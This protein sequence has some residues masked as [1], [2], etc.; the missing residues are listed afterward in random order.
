VRAALLERVLQEAWQNATC[1]VLPAE[2][3][4][5]AELSTSR[6]TLRQAIATLAEWGMVE[7]VRGSGVRIRSREHW[8]IRAVAAIVSLPGA[9]SV[10]R[11]LAADALAL[12][13]G[14]ARQLPGLIPGPPLAGRFANAFSVAERAW[15]QR[16]APARFVAL[17]AAVART[18]LGESDAWPSAWLWNDL[19]PVPVALASRLAEPLPVPGDYLAR[20]R[21][22]LGALE[23]GDGRT[24]ARTLATHLGRLDRELLR[25]LPA[26]PPP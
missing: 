12:R 24:A 14:L 9:P 11:H 1:G 23:R 10:A 3:G 2:R 4:L 25:A 20:Q 8:S 15:E 16:H 17:D 5:A 6:V 19:T 7:P 26:A 22:L 18:V 21:D 13:R